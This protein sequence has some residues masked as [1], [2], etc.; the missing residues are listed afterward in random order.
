MAMAR[1]RSERMQRLAHVLA[2]SVILLHGYGDLEHGHS[3]GWVY[4]AIG[5]AALS[6]GLAHHRLKARFRHVDAIFHLIEALMA[7]LIGISYFKAGKT[8]LPWV[9]F[10]A[11]LP[12]LWLMW[13]GQGPVSEQR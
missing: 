1:H 2:A 8:Y 3:M 6:L 9:S 5:A 4:I 7:V 10:A 11:A 12:Y 13:K